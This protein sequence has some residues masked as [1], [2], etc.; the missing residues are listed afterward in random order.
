MIIFLVMPSILLAYNQ[1]SLLKVYKSEKF[2]KEV[3][4]EAIQSV[5]MYYYNKDADSTLQYLYKMAQFCKINSMDVE[6]NKALANLGFSLISYCRFEEARN[7]L[8]IAKDN[9]LKLHDVTR[10]SY[11]ETQLA[12]IY[13]KM[14]MIIEAYKGYKKAQSYYDMK[15]INKVYISNKD[16]YNSL[17]D[18]SKNIISIYI[19]ILTDYGLFLYKISDYGNAIIIFNKIQVFADK[20]DDMNRLSGNYVNQ[21]TVYIARK[22]Y[23]KA[24]AKL[25]LAIK[26]T[27]KL[28]NLSFNIIAKNTLANSYLSLGRLTEAE[29]LLNQT[30]LV[31]RNTMFPR[32]FCVSLMLNSDLM[33]QKKMYNESYKFAMEAYKIAID[34]KYVD[35]QIELCSL[36]VKCYIYKNKPDSALYYMN[37]GDILNAS[38]E[39]YN[40]N[41]KK[42]LL[43][44]I[45]NLEKK[46]KAEA[47]AIAKQKLN[48][49]TIWLLL[50]LLL[51]TF[52][53][54]IFIMSALR[55]RNKRNRSLNELNTMKNRFFSIIAHDIMSPVATNMQTWELFQS[56][57]NELD[58]E[59]I[60][61][62]VVNNAKSS[63]QLYELT[64]N[65]LMW[66]RT[67]MKDRSVN[68]E[69]TDIYEIFGKQIDIMR[70]GFTDKNIKVRNELEIGLTANCDKNI[71]TFAVR[72][73]LSNALKFTS[74]DGEV[75]IS[76]S[77]NKDK[78]WISIADNGIGM[79]AETK[80]NLFKVQDRIV[81]QGTNQ[82]KGSGLGLVLCKEFL[83]IHKSKI[84]VESEMNK[85]TTISFELELVKNN[86]S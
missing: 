67:M 1:D 20:S 47:N 83:D 66:A 76:S 35:Q 78:C 56:S 74:N 19:S 58:K 22:K 81:S 59:M 21:A 72:N 79:N 48:Q 54:L 23:E 65:L 61:S 45:T 3:R 33:Y 31:G 17:S 57:Y 69:V 13:S 52:V 51:I 34:M 9:F 36:L 71:I 8:N 43:V 4:Y 39:R 63:V 6:Y 75:V 29:V 60:D 44:T 11:C 2:T 32:E 25:Q 28:N 50:A 38:V 85:G 41:Y 86:E 68:I 10:A 5:T 27:Q 62:L 30:I 26:L 18:S 16:Y 82:E 73:L 37:L 49:R 80:Q 64:K 53:A 15:F 14:D 84:Y 70:E 12:R 42:Q 40:Q 7:L 55:M 46:E 77:S 24:Y